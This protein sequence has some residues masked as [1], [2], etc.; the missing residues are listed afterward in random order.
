MSVAIGWFM[1]AIMRQGDINKAYYQHCAD[2]VNPVP[3]GNHE[4]V[5]CMLD[6]SNLDCC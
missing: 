2:F 6:F 4:D 1:T 5:D 3:E